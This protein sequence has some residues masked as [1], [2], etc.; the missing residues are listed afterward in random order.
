M[1]KEDLYDIQEVCKMLGTT[2][3]TLRFYEEKGIVSST[4]MPFQSR[5]Q[6]SKE[7]IDHIRNVLVLRALGISVKSII[8]LQSQKIDLRE[9]ILSRR[10]EIAAAMDAKRKELTLL[11]EA[12]TVIESGDD[13]FQQ[14][15]QQEEECFDDQLTKLA[16]IC[17]NAVIEGDT[18]TLYR[19][20]SKKMIEYMPRESYEVVRADTLAPAGRLISIERLER[21]KKYPHI[22]YQYA[23][24]EKLGIKIK[25][26]FH[27]GQVTGLWIGYYELT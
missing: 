20:L 11:N 27:H 12:L 26:V 17:S 24:Y 2:S 18:D 3:R 10:A 19:H 21:D 13:I 22:L 7:Q 16:K 8:A 4:S 5:R 1:K 6:Y 25:L 14:K 23:R 15:S 9:A